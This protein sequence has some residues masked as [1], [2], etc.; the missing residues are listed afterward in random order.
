MGIASSDSAKRNNGAA[1]FIKAQ[2]YNNV[3]INKSNF[4][5][6]SFCYAR[7][8]EQAITILAKFATRHRE[9]LLDL[10]S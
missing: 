3:Y 1:N 4:E 6:F 8:L 10:R 5:F 7:G 9:T 2:N